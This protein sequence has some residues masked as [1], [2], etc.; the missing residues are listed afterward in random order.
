MRRLFLLTSAIVFVATVFYAALTPL[1]P[2]YAHTLD[3]GKTGAGVLSAAYPAGTLL[4]AVPSGVVAARVGVKPSVLVGLTTVAV[5]T[6]LFGIAGEA[7]QLDVAR[8]AQ[9]LASAFT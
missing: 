8:F 9:G 3:L 4:G 2:H 5:C 7:W 6:V 1:L